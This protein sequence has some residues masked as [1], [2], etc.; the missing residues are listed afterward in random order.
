MEYCENLINSMNI[1]CKNLKKF[2]NAKNVRNLSKSIFRSVPLGPDQVLLRGAML[3]NT[4]WV[5]GVVIY[6]GHD[7][8]LMQNNTTTAPLKRSTLDRLTNTQ[9]LMLFFI[10]LLLCLLSSIFNI[11]WTKANSDGLWYLGLNG[12]LTYFLILK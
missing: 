1:Y 7:T 5:F 12:K 2:I 8:K 3:R 4:R 10:L 11:L 6:T 9:I